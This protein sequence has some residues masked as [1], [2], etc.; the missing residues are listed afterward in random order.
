MAA[1]P[2]RIAILVI[3]AFAAGLI[4]ARLLTPA[5]IA[6]PETERA[7]VLPQPRSLPPLELVDQDGRPLPAGF[8]ASHWTLVFFGF[9]QCPDICPTTLATLAQVRTQLADLPEAA[10][11]R[12]LLISIDPERDPPERLAAYVRF[13]DPAFLGA[14]GSAE[15]TAAAAAAFGVP[16]A[17]V[18]M[19]EGG[20]TMDHGSG[21]FLVGP[22]GGLVAY[23]SAPHE[24]GVIARDFRRILEWTEQRR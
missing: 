18:E 19:P 8:F 12:V 11:P 9:T 16:Y 15:A 13:F 17:R 1:R 20:Y 3:V 10:R 6:P 24:A 2:L 5:R 7:T 22:G 21:L 23:L 14:S 4:L